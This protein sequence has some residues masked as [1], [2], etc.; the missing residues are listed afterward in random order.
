MGLSKQ[1]RIILKQTFKSMKISTHMKG[2][3]NIP[4]QFFLL[5][6]TIL[7]LIFSLLGTMTFA[8]SKVISGKVV[9]QDENIGLPGVNVVIKGTVRGTVTDA[10]GNFKLE[11][12]SDE[13]VLLFSFVGYDTKEV[14]VGSKSI[15]DVVLTTGAEKLSEVVI[16]ALGVKRETKALGYAIQEV[17]G[18]ELTEARETNV[19]NSLAGKVAGVQVTN[20]S[21]GIGSTSRIVIRGE[22]S[23][24]PANNSPL[25][26]VDGIPIDNSTRTN[27]TEGN[28]E[29]DY[30]NGAGD[31]N[32]D[33]IESISVLKGGSASALYGS[34]GAN[35]VILITT[36]SGKGTK[37]IGVS[38]NAGVTFEKPLQLPNYQNEYG[39]G[40]GGA[41]A[42]GDGF[43]GGINDNIDESWGP[44]LDG[45]LITQHDSPTSSG[46]RA[47]D[48][49]VRP[50]NPDGSFADT[51]EPTPWIAHPNNI[52]DFFETGVTSNFNVALSGGNDAGN[53][54]LS[55]TNLD[56]KGILPNTDLERRTFALSAGYNLTDKL[57][58]NTSINYINSSS[59]NRPNNSYGTENIMYLWVWFGRQIDMNSLKG[60]W[61]PGLEGI[62]Q[63]NYNYNWHDN[64]YFT[65]YENT[66][67]FNKNRV[68]GNFSVTYDFTDALSLMVRSG[69]DFYNDRRVGKRA[70]STQRFAHGQYKEEIILFQETNT[71]FLLTFD[72]EI[73]QNFALKLSVGANRRDLSDNYNRTSAN[74]LLVPNVYNFGNSA[75]PLVVSQ[76]D[77]TKRVN[78]IYGFANIGFKNVVFLDLTARNDWSSTLPENNNSYFYPSASLSGVISDMVELPD[79]MSFAKLRVGWA[80]VGNDTDPYNLENTFGFGQPYGT[81]PI[82]SESS[83]LKNQNLKPEIQTSF[84]VGTDLR[85]FNNRIGLDVTYY[86]ANSKN[87]IIGIPVDI[88]SGYTEK[89]IN[90]GEINNQG[91]EAMLF[92]SPVQISNGFRWDL[93]IN[94]SRNRSKVIELAEGLDTC[95]F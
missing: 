23:L 24:I 74:Q 32:P 73:N 1:F 80:Q 77:Q 30:G 78:S 89:I 35:G 21:S 2:Y 53:F 45:R 47:G 56:N 31:I 49:A 17:D 40:A 83:T 62:Q 29:T 41:F 7:L 70:F 36:K 52:K 3:I 76:Y 86:N 58:I 27:R 26:V 87:Q 37:G 59:N 57:H 60:Y 50:R 85:F 5:K 6:S 63:F 12:A 18:D 48:S 68:I 14:Q 9:A 81:T 71:D 66:N 69:T 22:S 38:V 33:D 67:A 79:F 65:M 90:A 84:E 51:V 11:I 25:F 16:T 39:Q 94:Y 54:R 28:L 95:N 75:I 20:G 19:V 10:D 91:I 64:P 61:Q 82:A 34:R 42:F 15:L 4:F 8:Q 55:F 72:K 46:F 92:A 93:N 88:T 13:D 44:R 43:G